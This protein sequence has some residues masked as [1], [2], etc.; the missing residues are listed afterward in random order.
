MSTY[1]KWEEPKEFTLKKHREKARSASKIDV[2]RIIG[3]LFIGSYF[4]LIWF[5]SKIQEHNS[6]IS[7]WLALVI[8]IGVALFIVFVIPFLE[9]KCSPPKVRIKVTDKGIHKIDINLNRLWKFSDIADFKIVHEPIKDSFINILELRDFD[10]LSVAMGISSQISIETLKS[11]LSEK[12]GSARER[13]KRSTIDPARDWRTMGG[14]LLILLG[15]LVLIPAMTFFGLKNHEKDLSF[16]RDDIQ[17]IKSQFATGNPT[18]LQQKAFGKVASKAYSAQ[19]YVINLER[20][21]LWLLLG[22][23]AVTVILF[24]LNLM[25]WARSIRLFNKTRKLEILC[26]EM[27][28]SQN[29]AKE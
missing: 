6:V 26:S 2:R 19:Y 22:S 27:S 4:M 5:L 24:G 9:S 20:S 23:I 12:I 14:S 3:G 18:P 11:L 13:I 25:L 15:F 8:A 21:H 1:L 16:M 29:K 28:I 10:G 17:E 7:F